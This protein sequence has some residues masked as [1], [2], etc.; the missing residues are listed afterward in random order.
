MA[1]RVQE[2]DFDVGAELAA[3]GQAAQEPHLP[4]PEPGEDARRAIARDPVTDPARDIGQRRR[5]AG[6]EEMCQDVMFWGVARLIRPL[7]G[8]PRPGSGCAAKWF[9]MRQSIR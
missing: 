1:V 4:A 2:A 6:Y 5:H 3:R 8:R 7:R 9:K